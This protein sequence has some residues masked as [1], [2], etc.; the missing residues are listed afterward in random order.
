MLVCQISVVAEYQ[1][2]LCVE[3]QKYPD[4]CADGVSGLG[5]WPTER[6]PTLL[7][8]ET[9]APFPP[10][11]KMSDLS[12]RDEPSREAGAGSNADSLQPSNRFPRCSGTNSTTM[13][14]RVNTMDPE[15]TA[16]RRQSSKTS[17]PHWRLDFFITLHFQQY[18]VIFQWRVEQWRVVQEPVIINSITRS[19]DH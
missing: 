7:S 5:S 6:G 10:A 9:Q 3:P 12:R 14:G 4:T 15:C 2:S 18:S 11:I 16:G 17:P 19:V 1:I 8:L 13:F